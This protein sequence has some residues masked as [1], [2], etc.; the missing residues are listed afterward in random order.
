MIGYLR[1]QLT[2]KSP[3][4]VLIECGGI[5]YQVFIS[6]NTF[7]AIQDKK[8]TQLFTHLHVTD[9]AHTLYGF[10]SQQEKEMFTLLISV[11]GVGPSTAMVALS[12]LTP[13]ELQS[14]ILYEKEHVV[15]SIKGIGPK[16]AKRIILELKDKMLKVADERIL[17][18]PQ[19]NSYEDEA[20]SA[21]VAL[22]F[23]RTAAE[24]AMQKVLRSEDE[25]TGVEHLIKNTLKSL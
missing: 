3:T 13:S 18:S 10:A 17:S 21:L 8:E 7:S 25:I 15:K 14:A 6:L 20:L 1:G 4:G 24:K 12:S 22:G 9:S 19:G 11:S 5:G 16:T 2:Y 23:N